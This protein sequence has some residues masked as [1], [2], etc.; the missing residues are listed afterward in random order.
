MGASASVKAGLVKGA[1]NALSSVG[2]PKG[3]A[4]GSVVNVALSG[5]DDDES[6]IGAEYS[7]KSSSSLSNFA[8][9]QAQAKSAFE[10][11]KKKL[12]TQEYTIG[13]LPYDDWR[14]WAASVKEKPMP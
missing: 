2:G 8:S 12:T 6:L 13:G 3:A 7:E 9:N 10:I 4:I 14:E 5:V 1:A 11:S